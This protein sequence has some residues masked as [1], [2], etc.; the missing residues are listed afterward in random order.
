MNKTE[1]YSKTL[2]C[3]VLIMLTDTYKK[4]IQSGIHSC[5]KTVLAFFLFFF[6]CVTPL[7]PVLQPELPAQLHYVIN[8][9]CNRNC[10]TCNSGLCYFSHKFSK[11][12]A[13]K[14]FSYCNFHFTDPSSDLKLLKYLLVTLR[15]LMEYVF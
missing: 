8:K 10:K 12:F 1:F 9:L 11:T 2:M 3:V 13:L 5:R 4:I 7:P 6:L 15:L 14:A